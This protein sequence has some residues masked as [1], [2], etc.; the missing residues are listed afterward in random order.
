LVVALGLL[1]MGVG[2]ILLVNLGGA[3]DAVI[4]RLTS[5]N[6]GELAPG[7]AASPGG[8]RVYATLIL[9]LGLAVAGVSISPSAALAGVLGIVLGVVVFVT[10][11]VI[12]I[13]GEL[14]TYRA[15]P[16]PPRRG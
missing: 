12:A 15:L 9:A 3:A 6:L 16:R 10:A 14:R 7:Y 8:F 5:R 13:K 11:S 2:T 4:R 1:L